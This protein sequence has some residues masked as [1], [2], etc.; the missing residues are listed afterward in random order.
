M[1]D[2][3]SVPFSDFVSVEYNTSIYFIFF[4]KTWVSL[5]MKRLITLNFLSK[6]CI[7]SSN[8]SPYLNFLNS[9]LPTIC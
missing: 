6:I 4:Y 2:N 9:P 7:V 8:T 1:F 3:L 5:L